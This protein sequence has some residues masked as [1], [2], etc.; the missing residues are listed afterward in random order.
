MKPRPRR[1]GNQHLHM[2]SERYRNAVR[3]KLRA[4]HAHIQQ[5]P[6]PIP[7]GFGES[8]NPRPIHP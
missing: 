1:S 3:R 2:E 5:R 8:L 6:A 4:Y 7:R